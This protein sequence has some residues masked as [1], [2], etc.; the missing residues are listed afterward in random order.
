MVFVLS[1]ARTHTRVPSDPGED[2]QQTEEDPE[3]EGMFTSGAL[4]GEL[5]IS[6]ISRADSVSHLGF[7]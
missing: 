6:S 3:L 7:F 2:A 5:G 4:L 1:V